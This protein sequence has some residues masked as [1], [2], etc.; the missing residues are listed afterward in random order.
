MDKEQFHLENYINTNALAN[1]YE[2]LEVKALKEKLNFYE[3]ENLLFKE[4]IIILKQ[5]LNKANS[6]KA[7]ISCQKIM[8]FNELNE[9]LASLN[10]IDLNLLNDFYLKNMDFD[11]Q[12]SKN[13]VYSAMGIKFNISS[14]MSTLGFD[15]IIE[16]FTKIDKFGNNSISSKKFQKPEIFTDESIDLIKNKIGKYEEELNNYAY[17]PITELLKNEN[18]RTNT[19]PSNNLNQNLN[20]KRNF[21]NFDYDS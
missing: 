18:Y 21:F 19:F 14:A 2:A 11:L 15:S 16:A 3:N 1:S 4:E 7:K 12:N 20:F 8:L 17:K 5:E 9:L 13:L 6:E 10:K